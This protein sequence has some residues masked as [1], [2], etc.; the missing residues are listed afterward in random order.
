M[1]V[2]KSAGYLIF[3][4]AGLLVGGAAMAEAGAGRRDFPSRCERLKLDP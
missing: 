3:G 1:N 2:T 4:L